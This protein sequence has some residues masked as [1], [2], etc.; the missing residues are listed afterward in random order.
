MN[1]AWREQLFVI[2]MWWRIV[3]GVLRIFFALALLRVVGKPFI[4]VLAP[5][6]QHELHQDPNDFLLSHLTSLLISHPFNITYFA[7]VYFLFWGVVDIVLSYNLLKHNLW[8]F[9]ISMLLIGGFL[10]YEIFRFSHTHSPFL[11]S[12]MCLD[13]F[14]LWLVYREYKKLHQPT[15]PHT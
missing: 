6:M 8:A 12:V 11:F 2:G 13:A 1:P 4:D 15:T 9:P 5:L 14:I 7:A 3:Y 10:V